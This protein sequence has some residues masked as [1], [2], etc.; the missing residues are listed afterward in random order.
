MADVAK[1]MEEMIAT[2]RLMAKYL[3]IEVRKDMPITELCA[4]IKKVID[5]RLNQ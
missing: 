3:A 4:E 5:A 2:L 1:V